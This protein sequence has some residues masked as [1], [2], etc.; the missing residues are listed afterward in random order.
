VAVAISE[1][2]A[3][4]KP[5]ALGMVSIREAIP[6]LRLRLP[7]YVLHGMKSNKEPS[8]AGLIYGS[9]A[10]TGGIFSC[11]QWLIKTSRSFMSTMPSPSGVG[12]MSQSDSFVPQ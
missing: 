8:L 5:K 11:S 1:R 4:S 3:A 2:V 9:S 7:P 12:P 6:K 10:G